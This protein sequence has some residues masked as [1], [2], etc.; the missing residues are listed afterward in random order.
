MSITAFNHL[1]GL[2]LNVFRSEDYY[3]GARRIPLPEDAGNILS[4]SG[5]RLHSLIATS[6]GVYAFGDNA[7]G[8]CG[9]DPDQSPLVAHNHSGKIASVRIP[10]DSPVKSVSLIITCRLF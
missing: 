6:K 8:Q 1:K 7:H 9:Q 4:I 10:S 3:I 5:G 2:D